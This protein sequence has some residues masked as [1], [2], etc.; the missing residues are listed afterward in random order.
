MIVDGRSKRTHHARGWTAA[1]ICTNCVYTIPAPRDGGPIPFFWA[2]RASLHSA[3]LVLLLTKVGGVESNPGPTTHPGKHTPVIWICDLCDKR[4][5]KKQTSIRCNHT[6]W[7]HLNCTH[8]KQRQYKPDWRCTI[9]TP[10]QNVTTT[11][12]T[13]NTPPQHNETTTH[14]LTNNNQPKDK[15]IVIFQININGIINKIKELKNLVHNFH[16]HTQHRTTGD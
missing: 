15:N 4:I 13:D 16:K 6:R 14:P 5:N 1:D 8:I 12:I 11:P 3:W 9:H 10:T 7:V 2:S